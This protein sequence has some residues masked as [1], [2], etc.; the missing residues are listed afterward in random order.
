MS[1]EPASTLF[2]FQEVPDAPGR[3]AEH[4]MHGD[5]GRAAEEINDVICHAAL[6]RAAE[7]ECHQQ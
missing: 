4:N 7:A 1:P 3:K 5:N 2:V 6:E